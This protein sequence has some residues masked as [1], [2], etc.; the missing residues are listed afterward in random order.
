MK[1][2]IKRVSSGEVTEFEP[3]RFRLH[4]AALNYGVEEAKRIKDWPALE[5]AVDIK[6]GEQR[7]FISWWKATVGSPGPKKDVPGT[8][9]ISFREAEDL[10]GMK[11][12]RVSDLDA[13]LKKTDDYRLRL[14][15]NEY[16]LACLEDKNVR[17]TKGTGENEWYTPEKH[18]ELARRV[19]GE[20]DLD[21][22]SSEIAQ[23]TVRAGKFFDADKDGLAQDWF[24]RVWLNPPYAQPLISE[25]VS[26]MVEERCANNVSAAIML[27]HNYTD[28]SWFHQAAEIADAICFTRGRI[29]FVDQGGNECAPTQGQAFFY[30]GDNSELFS[31]TFLEAGFVV[32]C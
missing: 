16:V 6:I 8:R 22:A 3:E 25:F 11:Q 31:A 30:F 23:R 7:K 21:P 19:L 17:G 13:R 18:I 15:G 10:T 9:Y 29:K 4:D 28:T 24:G 27:T 12:Q 26:K 32:Q 14:L 5:R 2:L 1:E 20:I